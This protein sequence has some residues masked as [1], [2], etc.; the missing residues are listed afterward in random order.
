MK[1]QDLTL[2]EQTASLPPEMQAVHRR[3]LVRGRRDAL[4]VKW[5]FDQARKAVDEAPEPEQRTDPAPI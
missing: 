5:W 4:R 1:Q 3:M 2:A